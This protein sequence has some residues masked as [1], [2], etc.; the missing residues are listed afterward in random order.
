MGI[1]VATLAAA[2]AYTNKLADSLG[3]VKGAP[4][5]IKSI[6]EVDNGHEVTFSWIGTSGADEAADVASFN[7]PNE[8][9]PGSTMLVAATGDVYIL[10]TKKQFV[11]I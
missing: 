9:A 5:Q 8:A 10:N 6:T 1:N 3:A 2:K 7:I 4:C 11:Q